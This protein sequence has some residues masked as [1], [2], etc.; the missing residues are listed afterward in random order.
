MTAA[1]DSDDY[2]EGLSNAWNA[3]SDGAQKINLPLRQHH[4]YC[5]QRLQAARCGVGPRRPQSRS[6]RRPTVVVDIT[7]TVTHA[8][9]LRDTGRWLD[10]I[11]G[12]E[13]VALAINADR[14]QPKITI[15]RWQYDSANAGIENVQTIEIIESSEGDE[16]TVTG[17]P[18]LIPFHLF[19]L[20][21]AEP[22]RE[23]DILIDEQELKEIAQLI[24]EIQFSG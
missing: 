5:G 18:L 13:K 11:Y 8:K 15:E 24:W 14:R 17:G 2:D 7:I 12:L 16:V 10:P 22:S 23:D 3:R 20:G 4:V 6:P 21:P 19:F 1:G 9:L